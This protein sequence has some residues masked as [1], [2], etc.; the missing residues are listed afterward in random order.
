MLRSRSGLPSL[1]SCSAVVSRYRSCPPSCEIATCIVSHRLMAEVSATR[2]EVRDWLIV[3]K[4]ALVPALESYTAKLDTNFGWETR[5]KVEPA[6]TTTIETI[7]PALEWSAETFVAASAAVKPALASAKVTLAPALASANELVGSA[8]AHPSIAPTVAAVDEQLGAGSSTML[9]V[10][11]IAWQAALTIA[12]LVCL[13]RYLRGPARKGKGGGA[14]GGKGKGKGAASQ[15][16]G[17]KAKKAPRIRMCK[18][19]DVEVKK[20]VFQ[21]THLKGKRHKKLSGG[22]ADDQCWVW[23]EKAPE[24]SDGPTAPTAAPTAAELAALAAAADTDPY[25]GEWETVSDAAKKREARERAAKK[26]AEEKVAAERAPKETERLP[27]HRRCD[28]CGVRARD[29]ATIETDPD[30]PT[31]AYCTDCWDAY[32]NPQ[33]EV[34]EAPPTPK[35]HITKFNRDD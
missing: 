33:E 7:G 15:E 24:A 13:P 34:V 10:A 17:A 35:K 2:Q 6:I 5:I 19:C 1:R 9:V 27:V 22:A 21:Q 4:A 31:K 20:G 11:V 29:G 8:L 18:F 3:T 14:K 32:L 28:S 12:A 30:V 26:R 16:D 25:A 23:V